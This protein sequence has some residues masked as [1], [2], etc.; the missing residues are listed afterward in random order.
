M[1]V[2]QECGDHAPLT[3]LERVD[4][5]MDPGSARK[6]GDPP[7]PADRS[8]SPTPGRTRTATGR[9]SGAP[10][11]GSGALVRRRIGGL[12]VIASVMDFRFMGGAWE[13][14]LASL[15]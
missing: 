9:R 1:R 10:A 7:P 15:S 8:G 4:Q 6:F 3:A 2:C 13:P 11:S 5:L 14:Q 12:P